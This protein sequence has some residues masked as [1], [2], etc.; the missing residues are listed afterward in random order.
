MTEE[1][2]LIN[3]E[4]IERRKKK[5]EEEI[6]I[7]EEKK[8]RQTE[9]FLNKSGTVA[10]DYETMGRFDIPDV[11]HFNGYDVEDVNSISL[12]HAEDILENL[13]NILN[14]KAH[15]E[16]NINTGNMLPEEFLET[17]IGLKIQFDTP[18]H[19]H[20]WICICQMGLEEEDQ[21]TNKTTI[22]LRDLTFTSIE[23]LEENLR[24]QYKILMDEFTKEEFEQYLINKYG[25]VINTTKKEEIQ[26][27]K[28]KEPMVDTINGM[29]YAFRFIRIKDLIKGDLLARKKFAGKIKKIKNKKI[30]NVPLAEV[31]AQKQEEIKK[32]RMEEAKLAILYARALSLISIDGKE[33]ES[34]HQKLDIFRK[35]PH[36]DSS[37]IMDFMENLKFGVTTEL[38]LNC[39]MCGKSDR[40]S[41]RQELNPLELVPMDTDTKRELRK[42]TAINIHFGI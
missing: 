17:L 30:H 32:I 23:D 22:D 24:K 27:I 35:I 25:E 8:E 39:P 16:I 1:N 7:Q 5:V 34:D 26:K 2:I 18:F 37:R 15:S 10:I 3:P 28:I 38:E 12:S 14:N 6:K 21:T 20:A 42:S 13:V 4:D 11:L 19:E 29:K 41:L 40:R 33:I 36:V 31:K 9:K